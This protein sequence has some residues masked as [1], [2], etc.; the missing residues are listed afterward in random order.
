PGEATPAE[1]GARGA[2]VNGRKA[3]NRGRGADLALRGQRLQQFAYA[4]LDP[5]GGGF[6]GQRQLADVAPFGLRRRAVASDP[7]PERTAAGDVFGVGNAIGAAETDDS[8]GT[9]L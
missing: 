9:V 3:G 1:P 8:F 6:T 4:I 7:P 5:V 2:V